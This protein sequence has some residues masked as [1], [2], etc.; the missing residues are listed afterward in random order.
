MT[1]S[2]FHEQLPQLV[3]QGYVCVQQ[4]PTADLY[5]YN[6][7]AK[8]QYERVWNEVTLQCRG[9]I[10]DGQGTVVARPFRKFF[11]LEEVNALPAEPFEV[12]E[13]MDGS[14]GILYWLNGQAYIATRGSFISEQSQKANHLLHTHYPHVL[15][16][17]KRD[18]T[19][20]FEIIYPENRIVVDYGNREDLVLLAIID[21]ATGEDLPLEEVGFPLVERYDGIAD[22]PAIRE[23]AAANKEGF[24]VKFSG[25][26]RVK[27][28]FAEY[29]RL[30]RIITQVSSRNIWDYLRTGASFEELLEKVPDEFYHWVRQTERRL[31]T[32]HAA[33]EQEARQQYES[34]VTELG[35]NFSRKEFA[36]R[37]TQYRY[38]NLLFNLL[39]GRDIGE[40]IWKMIEPAFDKPFKTA[41]LI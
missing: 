23:M 37:A 3:Q 7:T 36:A 14:L 29:V 20:L 24:V 25:G 13:K 26:F 6:Y 10:L 22:L 17:L 27:V 19:Y 8:A 41:D 11:N 2:A 31:R 30:H 1:H 35:A 16:S 18:R 32:E 9:L 21:A 39:D 15:P 33:L 40:P 34:L 28:K 4:H 38:P 5:I 12:Y